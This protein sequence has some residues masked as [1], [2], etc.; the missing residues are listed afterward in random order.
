[1]GFRIKVLLAGQLPEMMTTSFET[2]INAFFWMRIL[3]GFNFSLCS[4]H[5]FISICLDQFF[6]L[7]VFFNATKRNEDFCK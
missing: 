1:M 2:P 4:K 3:F 6:A 7:Y 5:F